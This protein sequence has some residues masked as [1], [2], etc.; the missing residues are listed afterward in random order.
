MVQ[1]VAKRCEA[2]VGRLAQSLLVLV[3]AICSQTL[4]VQA[5]TT[6]NCAS[7]TAGP[8]PA[9]TLTATNPVVNALDPV[10]VNN[11]PA[12]TLITFTL[13]SI[14]GSQK[15]I[16]SSL[17]SGAATGPTPP[18][19][20]AINTNGST[21]V[22]RYAVSSANSPT[23]Q[24]LL[25]RTA[26]TSASATYTVACNPEPT[27][28][29]ANTTNGAEPAT[30]GVLTVTQSAT[31][32]VA[33]VVNLNYGGTATSGTD[34]TGP[35]SVTIPA[36]QTTATVTLTMADDAI[37]EGNETAVVTL[38]SVAS[39]FAILGTTTSATNTI[40]DNDAATVSI[41]NTTNGSEPSANGVLTV[42]Q[43]AVSTINT[44]VNLS[45]AGTATSGSDYSGPTSVTIPAGQTTATVTLTVA[46]DAVVEGSETAVVTL[47][48]ISSGLATLGTTTS[49]TNTIADNDAA[50]V[51]IANTTN[52][53]EP[54][55]N[56]VLTVSQS[57]ISSVNTVVN[58]SFG[59]TAT[60][61]TDYTGPANVT[62]PAGQTTATVTLTVADDAIVEGSETAVVTLASVASGLA[63]LGTTQSA[64]NTIA[65]D[66]AATVTIANTTDAAEPS[67]N[68]V[69]TVTQ[70]AVSTSDTVIALSY[71]GTAAKPAD[72]N[73][74]ASV[75]IPAGQTT[76]TITLTVADDA[77]AEGSETVDV[78]LASITSGLA[79]LGT[80]KTA[81]NTIADNDTAT[82]A[83]ANTTNGAEPAT[84]G[85]LTVTQ[86]TVSISDTVIALSY[87]G[88]A[89]SGAD[90]T[91][92]TS[93][94]IS[95]GQTSATI[96]LAIT[97]DTT[98]EGNETAVVTLA[99][100]TSG[101]AT[102][103]TPTSA[104]TTIADN[105]AATV[106][107]ANTTDGAEPST[108]GVLTVTQSATSSQPTVIALS[109]AGMASSG[110]DFSG[111]SSV[112]IP[113]GQTTATVT[114]TV[115]DDA[116]VEGSETVDVTLASITSGLA[117]LGSTTSATTTIADNDAATVSLANTTNGA[118]PGTNG[119]LTVTQSAVSTQA[120]VITLAFSGSANK[121]A[122]YTGPASV[123]IPAGHTSA[124][125]TLTVADD[126]L[127]EGPETVIVTLASISSGSA[128]L[129]TTTSATTTIADNDAATV[130]LA[131]TT[132][133]AEPGT[134]GV[135]TLTQ[136]AV[137]AVDTV[138]NLTYGGTAATPADYS[139]P[140]TVTIP[141]GQTSAT[142]TLTVADDTIVEGSETAVVTL[143]S[144]AS[145]LA[146][147][148][149]TT[150]A[151]NTIADND[152][153]TVTIANTTNGAEPS[154][155]GVLTV[156]Q[157]SV[158]SVPTVIN[159]TYA[160]TATNGTDYS[161]PATVTI[162]AGQTST[163]ITL[164]VADDAAPEGSET[165]IVTLA[166]IASG[167]GTLGSTTSA[168]NTITDNDGP[169][170]AQVANAFKS[171]THGFMA[172]RAALI[173]S[174]EPMLQR[175]INRGKTNFGQ[176]SNGFNI[177]GQNGNIQGQ[178]A[179]SSQGIRR[180]IA[181]AQGLDTI[182]SV[183]DLPGATSNFNLWT[184]GQFGL[185]KTKGGGVSNTGDFFVGYAGADYRVRDNM[186]V[187]LMGELDWMSNRADGSDDRVK[188]TGWMIGPYLSAE[189]ADNLF[190][191]LR[192]MWGQSNNSAIQTVLGSPYRGQ[193]DTSRWLID[194]KLAGE[195]KAGDFLMSPEVTL[196]YMSEKQKAYTASNGL[197]GLVAVDGQTVNLGRLGAGL[198][199]SRQMPW[200]D[201]TFEPYVR[202]RLL[203]DFDSPGKMDINGVVTAQK[204][205]H[206]QV[207]AGF[208]LNSDNTT[209]SGEILYDGLG[210]K[211]LQALT[212]KAMFAYSF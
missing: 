210:S 185:F 164:T 106:T 159:L 39:G 196:L 149:T 115:A 82:V 70:S 4:S 85:M 143:A 8:S 109:Y 172:S 110:A 34:Y 50:T 114:L 36:G 49:A 174:H 11:V 206:T 48:S 125:I 90:Y 101:I 57:A 182:S 126:T 55:T 9:V 139:G 13:T 111:P 163:T 35:T 7:G 91:G 29:I 14:N 58:L 144:I 84:N 52:G 44:V 22:Q 161:G 102:L 68:G 119:V 72:Y 30:N 76:A 77:I 127:V 74:P 99:F 79:T 158:S 138:I 45:Y 175:L 5:A 202:G 180:A 145:G 130:S 31:S 21:V 189:P 59:G 78:T 181:G 38:A 147:L 47:A 132:N 64:T 142:L 94:T 93:V 65:D 67:T 133:S 121:P 191:D 193:F 140:A 18:G 208:V 207:G 27:V 123:T 178:F 134:N 92:P 112:T 83:I 184:E 98:V 204:E 19:P 75:T 24:V 15:T 32:A 63:T 69:L 211:D 203:W 104:T 105:D 176:D 86:S 153:A 25:T 171:E 137:S 10:N 116:I 88:T 120:T 2:L 1:A 187:G 135:L 170:D 177:T 146:T 60:N 3:I 156:T 26:A 56:G 131:N 66:D 81:T 16:N 53:A 17:T 80:T 89:T 23:F 194:A 173:T 117:T 40:A 150:S 167:Q 201:M 107:I 37:V 179:F 165:V 43:S 62:I 46:D 195:Y 95:A 51:S 198:K 152:A 20:V 124:T 118:E 168:T 200:D 71:A 103:G 136:S 151:T 199:V 154:T 192:A 162:P 97:D 113:A 128:T 6:L 186:L 108:N 155:N 188:G 28:T 157:S 205:F 183:A 12:N 212:A 122:D 61:G 190:F 96:T 169:S 54:A 160:G 141:A 87:A 209:F 129:G 41:A 148:G 100:V 166:S 42:T 73:G 33:T 197:G